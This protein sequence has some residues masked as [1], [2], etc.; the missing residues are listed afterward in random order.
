MKERKIADQTKLAKLL[1]N[2]CE[3]EEK[4]SM[5]VSLNQEKAYNYIRH[6]FL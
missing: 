3:I 4:N 5:I 6:D 1:I 2:K